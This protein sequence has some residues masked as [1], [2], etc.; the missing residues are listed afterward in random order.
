MILY[1][2]LV[3]VVCGVLLGGELGLLLPLPQ[4]AKN[5]RATSTSRQNFAASVG[6][7]VFLCIFA[8]PYSNL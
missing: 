4:P 5:R 6:L 2:P 8:S 1:P 7:E 3:G